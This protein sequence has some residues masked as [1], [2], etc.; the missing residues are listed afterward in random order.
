MEQGYSRQCIGYLE[1]DFQSYLNTNDLKTL[2]EIGIE[3]GRALNH[4]GQT[5]RTLKLYDILLVHEDEIS[6]S[7]I[8]ARIY[9]QKA[10]VLNVS[11]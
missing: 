8:L 10:N 6:D 11:R 4:S 9:E 3:L 1:K 2:L 5:S 7:F